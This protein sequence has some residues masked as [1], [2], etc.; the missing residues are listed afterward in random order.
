VAEQPQHAPP[1]TPA[2]PCRCPLD[3]PVSALIVAGPSDPAASAAA[4]LPL[5]RPAVLLPLLP[6]SAAEAVADGW[7]VSNAHTRNLIYV[8]HLLRC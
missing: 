5:D 8:C 2:P 6:H 7:P 1:A 3:R 4:W